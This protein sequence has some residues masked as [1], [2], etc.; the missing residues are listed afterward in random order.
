MPAIIV[1]PPPTDA[2]PSDYVAVPGLPSARKRKRES[3]REFATTA[4]QTTDHRAASDEAS[5]RLSE[6]LQGIFEA[7]NQSQSDTFERNRSDD[8]GYFILIN[9]ENGSDITLSPAIQVKLESSLQKAISLR[10]LGDI[11]VEHLARLQRLCEGAISSVQASELALEPSRGDDETQQWTTRIDEI[12]LGLQAARTTLRVMTGGREE[13]E[14][15]SED[16]LQS[17]LHLLDSVLKSC[18]I[19]VVESRNDEACSAF[20]QLASSHRKMLSQLL[21]HATK[22]MGLIAE[23]LGAVDMAENII[24]RVEF[25]AT[26]VIFVENAYYEKDSILGI[27]K[28]ET[29]RRTAMDMITQIFTRYPEQRFSIF[30]QILTSLQKLPTTRQHA[31]QYKL[32]AGVSI[33]LVSALILRLVQTS[34]QGSR[35]RNDHDL[36]T[37]ELDDKEDR[38]DS[39]QNT[40]MDESDDE[41]KSTYDKAVQQLSRMANSLSNSA[42]RSAQYVVGF[43]VARAMTTPKTGDQPYRHLLDIFC[44]DLIAV[45]CLPEWPAAEL[46]LRALLAHLVGIAENPKSNAPAKNMALELL[47]LMGSAISGLVASTQQTAKGLDNDDSEFSG[48]LRQM[49]DEYMDGALDSGELLGWHGPYRAVVEYLQQSDADDSQLRSAQAYYLSQWGKAVA[50]SSSS[51]N[52]K[53]EK[54]AIQLRRSLSSSQWVIPE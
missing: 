36:G 14:L 20:F 50:N 27:Q 7:D 29:L 40:S 48:Y 45:L 16:L 21:H 30:D 52:P 19:P 43:F 11:P 4:T 10:R 47:G 54:L 44:E 24:N 2:R 1:P 34:A 41:P 9:A 51:A 35:A 12:E 42:R 25:F 33:Q 53:A 15:Y 5:A 6:L 46:L 31:R 49:L 8:A 23:L 37:L 39:D 38:H 18:I 3:E 22:V 17:V 32:S 28:F 26:N 13:K